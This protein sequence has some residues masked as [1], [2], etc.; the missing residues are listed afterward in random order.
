MLQSNT[1]PDREPLI[2]VG[3][4]LPE[5]KIDLVEIELMP[6]IEYQIISNE[7][8]L[9]I[10]PA[11]KHKF[12]VSE[13]LIIQDD[14][15]KS[16]IWRIEPKQVA[17]L[18]PEQGIKIKNVIAGR[19]F[20][21]E[22]IA[23]VYLPGIIEFS[24]FENNLILTNE[25][26]LEDYIICVV[27][28]EMGAACPEAFIKSQTIA[29]RSWMLANVEQKHVMMGMDVCNDDCCQRYHGSGNL[30]SQFISIAR[31]TS[32]QVLLYHNKI[33]D[34]RYSKSCGGMMET[35]K[36]IWVGD[37][38]HYLQNIPDAPSGFNHPAL[39]LSSEENVKKWINSTPDTFCSSHTV[40]ELDL[41]K[42]LGK[43]DKKG[44]YFR[45]QIKYSQN[46]L[47]ELLSQKLDLSISVILGFEAVK[48][49][50]SGR[51][52]KL[53]IL[54][55]DHNNQVIKI[56]I[57]SEFKIRRALHKAFLLSSCFYII[58]GTHIN[59]YPKN[60][61]IVGAG[62]GH[63]VGFCQIGALG[64]ALKGYTTNEIIRH[65]YPGSDLKKI[66]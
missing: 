28:S 19:G 31:Q 58:P 45:W 6:S 17:S 30:T 43:V 52:S 4:I 29:S 62:W 13:N 49:G 23:D 16:A 15:N 11:K 2:R 26:F 24:L 9:N 5:D 61:K 46:E 65:Y 57:D 36:T 55:M 64:M 35:F 51:L 48:R 25:L 18:E 7:Q 34:A 42:F 40:S 47:R 60:F 63:G 33:C 38:K 8:K 44:T 3:I 41:H 1:I 22:K 14:K 66:Y 59:G 27:N 32:G 21:W 50:G 56:L 20:H 12:E 37:D 10:L 53:R 54:F 39:P